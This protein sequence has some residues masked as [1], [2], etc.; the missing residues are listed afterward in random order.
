MM[1][2]KSKGPLSDIAK[3]MKKGALTEQAAR[4]GQ[5]P[6]E[7]CRTKHTGKAAKRCA[8]MKTFR[9]HA[10]KKGSKSRGSKR[11]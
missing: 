4:R 6:Q 3:H 2:E 5:S 8:L 11:G 10:P 7:F 9:K 1:A